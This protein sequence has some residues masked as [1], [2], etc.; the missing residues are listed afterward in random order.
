MSMKCIPCI[1][2]EIVL[3]ISHVLDRRIFRNFKM[4]PFKKSLRTEVAD[5]LFSSGYSNLL[6]VHA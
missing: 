1:N 6:S 5:K 2:R 4:S 3:F